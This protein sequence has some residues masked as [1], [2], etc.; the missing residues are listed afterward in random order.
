MRGTRRNLDTREMAGLNGQHNAPHALSMGEV[1][2]GTRC[3]KGWANHMVGLNVVEETISCPWQEMNHDRPAR[4]L[5]LLMP[6]SSPE[7][8]LQLSMY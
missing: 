4:T 7:R 5:S 3:I 1:V 6:D 2:T 8:A